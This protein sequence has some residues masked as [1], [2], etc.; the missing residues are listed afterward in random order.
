MVDSRTGRYG[1]PGRQVHIVLREHTGRGERIGELRQ[2]FWTERIAVE[3][4][5]DDHG[6]P[7]ELAPRRRFTEERV[8]GVALAHVAKPM[9]VRQP[10]A[11]GA[12]RHDV[13]VRQQRL[14]DD[15]DIV[16]PR[17][18]RFSIRC[19]RGGNHCRV[20]RAAGPRFCRGTCRDE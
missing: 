2:L 3:C 4:R 7:S 14:T 13:G 5:A 6:M 10:C 18:E 17:V 19:V 11:A 12:N 15:R 8:A 16:A 1:Q 20:D 9:V